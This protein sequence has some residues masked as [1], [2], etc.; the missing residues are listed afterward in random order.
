MTQVLEFQATTWLDVHK[1]YESKIRIE[2]NQLSSSVSSKG[3]NR[4]WNQEKFKTILMQTEDF[5]IVIF[6]LMKG[7]MGVEIRVFSHWIGLYQ[8]K[9]RIVVGVA[10]L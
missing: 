10:V 6:S 9:G 7:L 3:C 8:H 5:P 4:D 2:D 1:Y